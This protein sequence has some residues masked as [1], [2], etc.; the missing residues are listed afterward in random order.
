M[1][2]LLTLIL[3]LVPFASFAQTL[4]TAAIHSALERQLRDYPE[5]TLQDIYK[6]FYQNRFGT[7]HLVTDPAATERYL[8]QELERMEEEPVDSDIRYWEPIGADTQHVRV[9]LRAVVDGKVSVQQLNDAFVR[10]AQVQR[11]VPFDWHTEWLTILKVIADHRMTVSEGETD[12]ARLIEMSRT[13]TAAHHSRRY[14]AAYHPHYRVVRKEIFGEMRA[15][16]G[17]YDSGVHGGT[18]LRS[19]R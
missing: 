11:T 17:L 9:F 8:Y 10:S 19:I 12:S 3:V 7:G 16:T 2:V 1:K 15:Y 14:N 6:S 18:P 4:D 13:N 5:S